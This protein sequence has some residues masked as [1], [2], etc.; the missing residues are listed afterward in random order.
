MNPK[1][2]SAAQGAALRGAVAGRSDT[3]IRETRRP[4]EARELAA[5]MLR[6][7]YKLIVAAAGAAG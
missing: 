6:A 2:G 3:I 1:A 7:G 4:G 5:E